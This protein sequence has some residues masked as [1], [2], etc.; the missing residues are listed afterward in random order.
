MARPSISRSSRSFIEA[1]HPARFFVVNQTLRA[2]SEVA[3][4]PV[5]HGRVEDLA[6]WILE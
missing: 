2:E 1:Y 3:G 4:Q 5:T 6:G